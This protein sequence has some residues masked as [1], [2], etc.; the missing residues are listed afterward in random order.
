[1][2]FV[3]CDRR[4]VRAFGFF[5]FFFLLQYQINPCLYMILAV[6]DQMLLH[7]VPKA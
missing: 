6:T 4:W 5:L 7:S 1:M 3:N 2:I